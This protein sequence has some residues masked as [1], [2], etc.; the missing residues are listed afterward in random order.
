MVY[1][2]FILRKEAPWVG[3]KPG[4]YLRRGP[5]WVGFSLVLYRKEASLGGF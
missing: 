1:S 3:F 2:C 4:L 5:P